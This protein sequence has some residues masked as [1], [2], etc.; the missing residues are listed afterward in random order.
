MTPGSGSERALTRALRLACD[1]SA[2]IGGL[3]LIAMASVTVI[4]V[5]GRALFSTPIQGDVEL[6]QLGCAIVVAS[7]LPYTQFRHGNIIVDFFTTGVAA[8]KRSVMD[9]LGTLLYA[10]MMAVICWRVAAGGLQVHEYQETSA[11][12]AIPIW[13]P[14]MLMLPGFALGAVLGGVQTVDHL[15]AARAGGERV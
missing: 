13:I 1:I 7:F 10:I 6:V 14:Y 15:R 11:L 4:S 9:A 3:T 5:A 2:G 12:M 8:P